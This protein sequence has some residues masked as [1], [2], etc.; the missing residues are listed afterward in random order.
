VAHGLG[1]LRINVLHDKRY[2]E[3]SSARLA[4]NSGTL[5]FFSRVHQLRL[6]PNAAIDQIYKASIT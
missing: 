4:Q 6:H 3:E 1:L 5:A 2:M